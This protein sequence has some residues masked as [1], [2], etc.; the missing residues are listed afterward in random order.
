MRC[1][2]LMSKAVGKAVAIVVYGYL[3]AVI[4]VWLALWAGADR[5]WLATLVAFGP[6]WIFGTPLV[7]LVPA[8]VAVK[9][10]L[11]LPLFA[12][13]AVWVFPVMGLSLPWSRI[14]A[15]QG[16]RLRVLSCNV[17]GDLLDAKALEA[18]VGQVRPD[19]VLLQECAHDI[20]IAW[21]EG[22]QAARSNGQL[23]ATRFR[24][25]DTKTFSGRD[26]AGEPTRKYGLY[27]ALE[28]PWGNL[29]V[30]NV[31]LRTPR[32]GITPV[33]DGITIVKPSRSHILKKDIEGRR[34]EAKNLSR[35]LWQFSEPRIVAGDF[36]MPTDSAIYRR[37]WGTYANAFSR[38][39]FGFGRTRWTR[40]RWL[41]YGVRIDHILTD[42]NWR[43]CH[44]WL[45]PDIGSDHLP[46]IA[47]LY[48]T[49]GRL[50]PK[51]PEK[52]S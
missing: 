11:L 28:S 45:G 36:N 39:G 33:L 50:R 38:A 15:P 17:G 41:T 31:D 3:I 18:L 1:V 10:N 43:A 48:P 7:V 5:W 27:V 37:Y 51:H 46:V 26:P 19:V 29:G 2:Q 25:Q 35:W 20:Q 49:N 8:A 12:A 13:G 23:V 21:P 42:A 40:V 16:P 6:R 4:S 24:I 30:C 22:W 47:D 44:C 14:A 52:D 34:H 32:Y 9:R